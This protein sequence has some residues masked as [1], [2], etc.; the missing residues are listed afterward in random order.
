VDAAKLKLA[1][2]QVVS[3]G[4]GLLRYYEDG[5]EPDANWVKSDASALFSPAATAAM[6]SA[7][8]DGHQGALGAGFGIKAADPEAKLVLPGLAGAGASPTDWVANVTTYLDGMRAWV[9]ANR[10]G[11]FPADV[12]NVH[13]YCFGAGAFGDADP[14]PGLSPE[15]CKLA[16]LLGR[17]AAYRDQHLP[18][19]EVWLTEFGYDT[20]PH[21]RLRAPELGGNSAEIVQAQWIVRSFL[22][23]LASG[24]DRAFLYTSRDNC[25]GDEDACPDNAV[26]FSTAGILT[27]KGEEKAKPAWYFLSAFRKRLG[28]MRYAGTVEA[29]DPQVR[30]AKFYDSANSVG[31][32]VVWSSTSEARVV[33]AFALDVK[34]KSATLV[35]LTG[36]SETGVESA[37]SANGG[38]VS[39]AV[40]ETPSIVLVEGEP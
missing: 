8:Y 39:L 11:A 14:P 10:G 40:S 28:A 9:D 36:D 12:L 6:V 24:I 22:E 31:A 19:K 32:Y 29:S 27:Q 15:D 35:T 20:H 37:L 16:E 26:Q 25:T 3:S 30:I 33:E 17:I 4:L 38:H 1:P 2:G 13:E 5:N 18:G 23:L 21:S 34:P 7:D